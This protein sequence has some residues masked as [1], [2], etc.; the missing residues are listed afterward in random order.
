MSSKIMRQE[1]RAASG[2]ERT[3]RLLLHGVPHRLEYAECM[4]I[5]NLKTSHVS[6]LDVLSKYELSELL[7]ALTKAHDELNAAQ[8]VI[9]SLLG[10]A[11]VKTTNKEVEK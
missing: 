2:S 4:T 9:S 11:A 8:D 1:L 7:D 10:A 5:E 3:L 6:P